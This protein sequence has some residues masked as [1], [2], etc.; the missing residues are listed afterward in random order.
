MHPSDTDLPL[1]K[2]SIKVI[3]TQISKLLPQELLSLVVYLTP[4]NDPHWQGKIVAAVSGL[5][6]RSTL[7]T[8][9]SALSDVQALQLIDTLLQPGS[10]HHWKLSPLLVGMPH[11]TFL[12]LLA[13]ASP[14]QLTVLQHEGTMNS[15]QHQLT[16][17]CHDMTQKIVDMEQEIDTFTIEIENLNTNDLDRDDVLEMQHRIDLFGLFFQRLLDLAKKALAIAWNTKRP[18]LIES[19]NKIKDSCQKY[20]LYGIGIPRADS[21][22]PTYLYATLEGRLFRIFGDPETPQDYEAAQEEEPAMEGLMRLSV[23]YLQDYWDAG[24]LP[25]VKNAAEIEAHNRDASEE[26]RARYRDK[27]FAEAKG[28]LQRVGLYTVADLKRACIFS[29]KTLHE[30]ISQ[31]S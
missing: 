25:S 20:L 14:P 29:K 21:E 28:Q 15:V 2:A 22:P 23:R 13:H 27:L 5:N 11:A 6:D 12:Q 1:A 24:L 3:E 9:G 8:A 18:D 16:T 31:R 7:E 30:F 4:D 26:Q 10:G 17:F 19:I